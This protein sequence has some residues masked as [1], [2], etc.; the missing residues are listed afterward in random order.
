MIHF[1]FLNEADG[2]QCIMGNRDSQQE[3]SRFSDHC[4][5]EMSSDFIFLGACHK[6][7]L[8][9]MLVESNTWRP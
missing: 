4:R 1:P 8:Q 2:K 6:A 9:C 5:Q 3:G 7:N